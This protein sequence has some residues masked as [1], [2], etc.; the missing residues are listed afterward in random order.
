MV[1]CLAV[2]HSAW[3]HLRLF[4]YVYR[5]YV[6]MDFMYSSGQ[7]VPYLSFGPFCM[8]SRLLMNMAVIVIWISLSCTM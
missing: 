5:S 1:L 8:Y 7:L 3:D 6:V 4:F 2:L